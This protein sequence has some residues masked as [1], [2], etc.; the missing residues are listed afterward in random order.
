MNENKDTQ[1][2]VCC[3]KKNETNNSMLRID[4]S[5]F[6]SYKLFIF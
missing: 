6:L 5:C 3:H 2:F 1:V 4:I